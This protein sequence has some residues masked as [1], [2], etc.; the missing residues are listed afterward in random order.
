MTGSYVVLE[1]L[2]SVDIGS[3]KHRKLIAKE[4]RRVVPVHGPEQRLITFPLSR[5][6]SLGGVDE[7]LVASSPAH[8][9][10]D[11]R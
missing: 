5:T 11:G 9:G 4:I 3:Y 7:P 2:F 1:A 10:R 6:A 8:L